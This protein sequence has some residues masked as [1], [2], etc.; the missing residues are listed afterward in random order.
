MDIKIASFSGGFAEPEPGLSSQVFT[1]FPASS[2]RML[3]IWGAGLRIAFVG[4]VHSGENLVPGANR[5]SALAGFEPHRILQF[6]LGHQGRQ[7]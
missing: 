3:S 2:R 1:I 6:G 7:Q 4:L 5:K